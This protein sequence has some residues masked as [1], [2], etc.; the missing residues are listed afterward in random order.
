MSGSG[1]ART[2]FSITPIPV[3]GKRMIQLGHEIVYEPHLRVYHQHGIHQG[4]DE[5]RAK[6]VAE[7]I[8]YI[9][10]SEP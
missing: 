10:T 5:G 6:R 7:V 1:N 4:R 2:I 8:D 3:W 9:R